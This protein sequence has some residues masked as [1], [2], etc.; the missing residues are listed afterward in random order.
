MTGGYM[1][2]SARCIVKS[3][4]NLYFIIDCLKIRPVINMVV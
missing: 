3:T 2:N 1:L 4:Q